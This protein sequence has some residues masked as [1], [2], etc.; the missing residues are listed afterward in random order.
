[1]TSVEQYPA[2]GPDTSQIPSPQD[3]PGWAAEMLRRQVWGIISEVLGESATQPQVR[4]G[5]L[6]HI[7]E[8][9]GCP[10]RAL[11][12]HLHDR[13]GQEDPPEPWP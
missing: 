11:L 13:R 9:P 3:P 12:A 4:L 10:E 2:A 6:R 5:L 1:V 8:N 7:A